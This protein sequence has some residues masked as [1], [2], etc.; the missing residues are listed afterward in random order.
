VFTREWKSQNN[1]QFHRRQLLEK[2]SPTSI[3]HTSIISVI[4]FASFPVNIHAVRITNIGVPSTYV[5]DEDF[6]RPLILDCN[7]E[8]RVNDKGFVLK[9]YFNHMLVSQWIPPKKPFIFN[10]VKAINFW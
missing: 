2:I 8:F 5:I 9:W 3:I 4:N 1:R 10:G 7:Y 6:K